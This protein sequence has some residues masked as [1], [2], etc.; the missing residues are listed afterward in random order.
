M[1]A[2]AGVQDTKCETVLY[3]LT[4]RERRKDFESP[5]MRDYEGK[6]DQ[7]LYAACQILAS[8]LLGQ[9]PQEIQG[10]KDLREGVKSV[11]NHLLD[12]SKAYNKEH[13]KDWSE[14]VK[15]VTVQEPG[16]QF[17]EYA[18]KW[19]NMWGPYLDMPVFCNAVAEKLGPDWRAD[20]NCVFR[21]HR[22]LMRVDLSTWGFKEPAIEISIEGLWQKRRVKLSQSLEKIV[23][24]IQSMVVEKEKQK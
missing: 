22:G 10:D 24:T 11:H 17:I 16:I 2:E 13:E 7:I 8:R 9:H 5:Y 23:K 20:D 12:D 14:K 1:W 3:G 15:S 6:K 21:G 4:G 19:S 18:G